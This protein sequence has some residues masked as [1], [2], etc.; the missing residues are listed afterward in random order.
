MERDMDEVLLSQQKMLKKNSD[1]KTFPVSLADAF[2]KQVE[3]AKAWIKAQ[4]HV[5][6]L[7]L[8]YAD[9][10]ADPLFAAEKIASF[11][12][13]DLDCE[14]MAAS[15]SPDLYRNKKLK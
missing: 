4:P 15:V 14:K 10:I 9:V 1:G 13:E 5:E 6:V 11:I 12:D 3:K 8:N 2:T 7:Y